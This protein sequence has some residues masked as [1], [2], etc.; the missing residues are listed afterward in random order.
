[1]TN[2]IEY[3][4]NRLS[5]NEAE[6]ERA[7]FEQSEFKTELKAL[8]RVK[9][10]LEGVKTTDG[11]IKGV[12]ERFESVNQMIKFRDEQINHIKEDF[13]ENKKIHS[14]LVKTLYKK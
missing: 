12:N 11:L 4:E 7:K 3:F 5:L 6:L 8:A 1:M 9:A 10:I 13:K 2:G 14:F